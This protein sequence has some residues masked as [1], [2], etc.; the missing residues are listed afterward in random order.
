[1]TTK[2]RSQGYLLPMVIIFVFISGI[3]GWSILY[4]GRSER[5]ASKRRL[6]REQA[7]YLAEAGAQRALAY[8]KANPS[9][10]PDDTP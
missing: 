10:E 9:W 3:I 7:F 8:L 5:L 2:N 1:M 6:F 4:L